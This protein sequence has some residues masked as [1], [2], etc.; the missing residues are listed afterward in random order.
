MVWLDFYGLRNKDSAGGCLG[1]HSAAKRSY[2]TSEVRGS[3][4]ECQG[5][6]VQE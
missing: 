2:P 6:T 4:R 5:A 1:A 3:D